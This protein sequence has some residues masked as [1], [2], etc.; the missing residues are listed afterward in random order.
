MPRVPLGCLLGFLF[1]L[2]SG[3]GG[4]H[5]AE[6]SSP[7]GSVH[8]VSGA[9][10]AGAQVV[11]TLRAAKLRTQTDAR[12]E[13]PWRRQEQ[14]EAVDIILPVSRVEERVDVT[15]ANDAPEPNVATV[16]REKLETSGAM[17]VE[18]ALR[19][20]PGFK[21]YRRTPGWSTNGTTGGVS[22]RGVGANAASRGAGTGRRNSGSRS[23]RRVGLLGTVCERRHRPRRS[24]ARKRVG[25]LRLGGDGRSHQHHPQESAANMVDGGRD[26]RKLEYSNRFSHGLRTRGQLE[27]GRQRRGI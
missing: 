7:E 18:G 17:T 23:I 4:L 24:G 6:V 9:P 12:V 5:A 25:P 2:T 1:L 26:F 14:H 22:L 27:C 11:L 15:A 13:V 10:V 19:E 3:P 20:V 8:D 21:L 16:D